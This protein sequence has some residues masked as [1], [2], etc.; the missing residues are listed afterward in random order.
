MGSR[1]VSEV[2]PGS[3]HDL[4]AARIHALPV[5]YRAAADDVRDDGAVLTRDGRLFSQGRTRPGIDVS[6]QMA[7]PG[8]RPALLTSGPGV[9]P[10]QVVR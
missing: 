5:L 3:V 10:S 2:E 9:P 1:R 6:S 4:T 7:Q 8:G